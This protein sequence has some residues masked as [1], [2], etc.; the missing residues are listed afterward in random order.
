MFA[1]SSK[2]RLY[3][4]GAALGLLVVL[5]PRAEAFPS[6]VALLDV[7]F[8]DGGTATGLFTLNVYGFLTNPT[9]IVT[10]SG[11]VLGGATYDL[12]GSTFQTATVADF[13][14][15]SPPQAH[16]DEFGLS[17]VFALPLGSV[18]FDPIVGG[19]EYTSYACS[20]QNF[21]NITGGFGVIP[22]P[23]SMALMSSGLLV[24]G[25]ARRRVNQRTG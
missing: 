16:A 17:L 6:G 14:L 22:E 5:A 18:E 15:P 11:S 9:S 8:S 4:A 7:T 12:T 13:T 1:H 2:A 10:T 3:L 21:R 23:G 24:L 20:G 19:C 25:A